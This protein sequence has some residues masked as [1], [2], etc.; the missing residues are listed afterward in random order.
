MIGWLTR[1]GIGG[2]YPHTSCSFNPC[3]A[4][5][6]AMR[7]REMNGNVCLLASSKLQKRDER[8]TLS[9]ESFSPGNV[10]KAG[11]GSV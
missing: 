8:K 4:E 7:S 9:V 2:K 10:Q 1:P 6:R 3:G 5:E 11:A